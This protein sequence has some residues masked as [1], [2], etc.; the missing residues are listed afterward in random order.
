[1]AERTRRSLKVNE[2]NISNKLKEAIEYNGDIVNNPNSYRT[3]WIMALSIRPFTHDQKQFL[4]ACLDEHEA[5]WDTQIRGWYESVCDDRPEYSNC[6]IIKED[7]VLSDSPVFHGGEITDALRWVNELAD[8][9]YIAL[10]DPLLTP[11]QRILFMQSAKGDDS[12]SL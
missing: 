7:K 9:C 5:A 11:E 6:R 8:P 3:T 10:E 4:P 12:F 1:M 2:D